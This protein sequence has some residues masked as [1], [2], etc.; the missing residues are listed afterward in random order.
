[1]SKKVLI[2][3]AHPDDELLGCGG[4][5]L[6]HLYQGDK[7]RVTIVAEGLTSRESKNKSNQDTVE[8][9]NI[10]KSICKKIGIKELDFLDFADNRLDDY[11]LLDVIKPIE[12]IIN[13]FKPEIIYTHHYGDL[14]KDHQIVNRAV[15]TSARPKPNSFV[16][17]IYAFEVLSSTNWSIINSSA[18]FEPNYYLNI[19]KFL[20]KKL[21][22]LSHYKGEIEKWPHTRSLKSIEILAKYRGSSVGLEAAEAFYLLREIKKK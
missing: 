10:T 5:I 9:K 22:L 7:V 2:V 21:N 6:H 20:K 16:Q 11:N 4:A 12:K 14:N 18:V 19:E 13:T 15:M 8:L 3:A 17:K 1:M